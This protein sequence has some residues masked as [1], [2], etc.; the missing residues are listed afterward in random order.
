MYTS[1][2]KIADKRIEVIVR[3]ML[4]DERPAECCGI[5]R[6]APRQGRMIV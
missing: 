3:Q 5:G 6:A 4:L 1:D 2:S